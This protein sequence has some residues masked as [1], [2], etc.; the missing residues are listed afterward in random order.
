[1]IYTSILYKK[2]PVT[3]IHFV[4]NRCNARC[5][6]CFIDFDNP[7]IFKNELSLTEIKKIAKKLPSSVYNI[8]I[9][10][11]EPFLR[12]DLPQ[13]IQ[14]YYKLGGVTTIYIS[15]NGYFE[16]E[17]IKLAD[18]IASKY[19]KKRLFISIS[20][21]DFNKE[22]DK[23]RNIKGLA[24]KAINTYNKIKTKNYKN[25][26]P[27]I[28]MTLTTRNCSRAKE[29]FN[30]FIELGIDDI[31]LGVLRLKDIPSDKFECL[32]QAYTELSKLLDL[33]SETK[34]S[35]SYISKVLQ[36]KHETMR[37][38]ILKTLTKGKYISP[39]YAGGLIG[40]IDADGTVFPCEILNTNMGNLKKANYNLKRI[41]LSKK[42]Q[43]IRHQIRE[44]NCFCTFECAWTVNILFNPKY[45]FSLFAKT[46]FRRAK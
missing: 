34:F 16:K 14:A 11:G 26:T 42:A 22:H 46:F 33:K 35:K 45:Y 23:N 25:V 30:H 40:V 36:A 10:G 31:T 27:V 41:W 38:M 44:T 6:H 3:L 28:N 32:I 18:M 39:C 12:K 13:I 2:F 4:T 37:Q 7:K 20:L 5:E 19:P 15:T 43:K 24:V 17:I 1:M 9:T 21:D 29:I 8:N